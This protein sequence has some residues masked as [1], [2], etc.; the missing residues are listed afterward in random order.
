MVYSQPF[1]KFTFGGYQM[2]AAEIW[3]AGVN[4]APQPPAA[5][6]DML[7]ALDQISL[8]DCYAALQ[9]IFNTAQSDRRYSTATSLEWVK[10]AVIDTDGDYAGNAKTHAQKT[11]GIAATPGPPPP[12][13][14]LVV[15]L[16]DGQTIGTGHHGRFYL[17]APCDTVTVLEP[18]TGKM[19]QAV[20]D[21]IRGAVRTALQTI[22]GEVSTL[23]V[24]AQLAIMS[25]GQAGPKSNLV[26]QIGLGRVFD[27]QR[28]RRNQLDDTKS[29]TSY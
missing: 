22:Q 10:L 8:S 1:Y 15:S 20:A 17:P 11:T 23:A 4:F 24:P 26:T 6:G 28:R 21:V 19:S 3:N 18:T 2:T 9:P 14:A 12:Q 27:T 7:T 16:W 13:I 5:V 29:Y 25:Q